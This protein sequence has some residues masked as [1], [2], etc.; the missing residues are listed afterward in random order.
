MA[1]TFAVIA[2]VMLSGTAGEWDEPLSAVLL[3]VTYALVSRISFQ[4]GPGLV[5]ATQ[6][7]FVP[8][9]FI[10]PPLA[11]PALVA[12][13]SVLAVLPELVL[14]RV[15]PERVL[16]ALTDSWYAIGPAI[17]FELLSPGDPGWED[18][19]I[20]ALALAAQFA[21]DF[22]ATT[23]REHFGAGIDV[24][25]LARVLGLV[26]LVDLLL[27]PIGFLAVLATDQHRYAYLLAVPPGALLALVAGERRKR[28]ERELDLGR[29]Y[30][31]SIGDLQRARVRVGEAVASTLDR[32]ALE[33]VLLGA[34][35][36]AL[37]A[38]CGRLGQATTGDVAGR[39]AA[40][41]AAEAAMPVTQELSVGGATAVA[42]KLGTDV[43]AVARIGEPF[44]AAEVEVLEHLGAQGA[45]SLENLRLH[46]AERAA[47]AAIRELSTPVLSVRERLLIVPLVGSLDSDR[48]RQL[49][50]ALL[51]RIRTGRAL[52]VVIDV[53]GVPVIDT[54]VANQLVQMVAACGLLGARVVVT[55][56]SSEITQALVTAGVDLRAVR[57]VADLQR[58]IEEAERLLG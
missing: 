32:A 30:R 28:L 22:A 33:R 17:V 4:L 14:R 1:A 20:Y 42:V 47:A 38:D 6:L 29:A 2:V 57:A 11:V 24:R 43:L 55:G 56:L 39:E 48:A 12:I 8:L 19:G 26:Y 45:V 46:D 18:I 21:L 23:V 9:V 3:T 51:S 27:S 50:D 31:R 15:H 10:A 49:S 35:V 54:A 40:L 53:T 13:G 25:E 44:S 34:A 7:A 36:E 5:G 52:V 16:V 58:G 37:D 41:A